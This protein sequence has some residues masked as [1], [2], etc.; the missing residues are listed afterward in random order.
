MRNE[1]TL[2]KIGARRER[3]NNKKYAILKEKHPVK[4]CENNIW[5]NDSHNLLE[6]LT[7]SPFQMLMDAHLNLALT[8]A[9]VFTTKVSTPANAQKA[10][11]ASIVKQVS[12]MVTTYTTCVS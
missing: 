4:N 12:V 5:K 9:F 6:L 8:M 7:A 11:P 10:S 1:A 2:G 3:V